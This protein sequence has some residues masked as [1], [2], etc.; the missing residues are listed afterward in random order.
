M[1]RQ[2]WKNK[3]V[4]VT[5]GSGFL[6][7]CLEPRLLNL[8]ADVYV[9]RSNEYDVR[10]ESAVKKLFSKV[11]PDLVVHMAAHGGGIG[12]MRSHPG[13]I[14]YD[15]I[16]INTLVIEA[17]RKY[18]IK[19]FIGIGTVCSY[20]KF[21]PVPFR[22]EDLWDGYPE[23]T[24]ATYGLAKKMMLVQTQAYHQ[25]FGFNGIHL[26]LVNMYG[27]YDDFSLD[28]SHVIPALIRKF[29]SA[30]ENNKN[31]V[32][33]WGT[34]RASREFLYVEDAAEAII[35]ATEKYDKPEPVNIGA[36]FEISIKDLVELI[37]KL[38]SFRGAIVWD[39][40]K[41]DGQPRRRLDIT[42]AEKEFGFKAKITL[43]E[44][45]KKTIEWYKNEILF[46][47]GSEK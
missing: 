31:E 9:P 43:E 1:D 14:F 27:P 12:H 13:S 2:F 23:G 35:L 29:I 10:K 20:P 44:G 22:E 7:K 39:T 17:S 33:A 21:T 32:I 5:G 28:T 42:R 41:P 25:E 18:K 19:K 26:L 6:G 47:G 16:M 36:G 45:L 24:N 8:G 30:I 38:T 15:N 46:K 4:L 34:G 3:K 37:A 40:S 11:N